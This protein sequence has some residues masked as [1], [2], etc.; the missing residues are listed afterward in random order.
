LRPRID[1][2]LAIHEPNRHESESLALLTLHAVRLPGAD[3]N[4]LKAARQ[5]V[6]LIAIRDGAGPGLRLGAELLRDA[7]CQPAAVGDCPGHDLPDWAPEDR[8]AARIVGRQSA[9]P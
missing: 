4:L 6:D 3:P 8:L 2:L 1:A 5:A 9:Q 7:L